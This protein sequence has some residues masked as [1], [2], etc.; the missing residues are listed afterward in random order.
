MILP[1][2]IQSFTNFSNISPFH[3][4]QFSRTAPAQIL[5]TE[6]SPSGTDCFKASPLR[7]KVPA[8]TCSCVGSSS[9]ASVPARSLLLCGFYMRCNF[10]LRT[11]PPAQAWGPSWAADEYLLQYGLPG[12]AEGQSE[13]SWPSP[14]AAGPPPLPSLTL[15]STGLFLT[16]VFLS[17]H[18]LCD[19]LPYLRYVFPEAPA[20]W[21]RHSAWTALVVAGTS[22]VQHGAALA[23]PHRG[24]L[25]SLWMP[26]PGYLHPVHTPITRAEH[27]YCVGIVIQRICE[28][29]PSLCAQAICIMNML[30]CALVIDTADIAECLKLSEYLAQNLEYKSETKLWKHQSSFSSI[31]AADHLF[32]YE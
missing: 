27:L 16:H 10:L 3:G 5:S 28:V 15:M 24:C 31:W 21:L 2:R 32:L 18:W 17:S 6:C 1:N 12:V 13:S 14:Q 29:L 23:S 8:R 19:I 22:C 26:A 30:N 25:C 9:W 7:A 20:P 11:H 4:V